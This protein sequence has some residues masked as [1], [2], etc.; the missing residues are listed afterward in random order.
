MSRLDFGKLKK[1]KVCSSKL[2]ALLPANNN[3]TFSLQLRPLMFYL[4]P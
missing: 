1:L 3:D 4:L 2:L